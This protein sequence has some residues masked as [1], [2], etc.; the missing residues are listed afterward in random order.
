MV[1]SFHMEGRLVFVGFIPAHSVDS[2]GAYFALNNRGAPSGRRVH[3]GVLGHFGG[4]LGIVRCIRS[5]S[6]HSWAPCG[7]SG[8]IW[9]A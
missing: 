8:S 3:S 5:C 4:R 9:V 6:I 1:R 2:K 7:S